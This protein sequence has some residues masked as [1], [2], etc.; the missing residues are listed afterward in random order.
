MISGKMDSPSS[1]LEPGSQPGGGG[2]RLPRC[3]P[4]K[5]LPEPRER[6]DVDRPALGEAGSGPAQERVVAAAGYQWIKVLMSSS[7]IPKWQ[8]ELRTDSCAN[9]AAVHLSGSLCVVQYGSHR[10]SD[11]IDESDTYPEDTRED[12]QHLSYP[13]VPS[14]EGFSSTE[15]TIHPLDSSKFLLDGFPLAR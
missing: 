4:D 7:K 2:S 3:S 14:P 9:E 10:G 8:E 5:P 15:I 12:L 13:A 6:Q 1:L 11:H